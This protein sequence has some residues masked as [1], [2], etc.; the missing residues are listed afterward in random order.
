MIFLLGALI[1]GVY[2]V[3]SSNREL[4]LAVGGL[5]STYTCG[6]EAVDRV[7]VKSCPRHVAP[8]SFE[9]DER[10]EK[11]RSR[12][13]RI[14]ERVQDGVSANVFVKLSSEK[15]RIQQELKAMGELS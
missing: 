9:R 7:R 2:S 4:T 14:Y 12:L 10:V 8:G 11:L 6:C 13:S 5:R 1:L 15:L 3:W